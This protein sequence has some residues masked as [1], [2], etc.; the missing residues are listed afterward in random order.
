MYFKRWHEQQVY[1]VF[2]AHWYSLLLCMR[3]RSQF[4]YLRTARGEGERDWVCANYNS[5][6]SIGNVAGEIM[7]VPM[8]NQLVDLFYSEQFCFYR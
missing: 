2:L 7:A 1:E 3:M 6:T 5:D 8:F 4:A